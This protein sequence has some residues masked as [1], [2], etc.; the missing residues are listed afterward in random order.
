MKNSDPGFNMTN[1]I[2]GAYFYD[3]NPEDSKKILMKSKLL[4]HPNI[5]KV[6]FCNDDPPNI[7]PSL[8]SLTLN[9]IKIQTYDIY[10]HPGYFDLF[11]IP[12]VAGRDFQ[13]NIKA[14]KA[15]YGE[16]QLRIILNETAA[17]KFNLASPVGATGIVYPWNSAVEI[18]G[19]VKDFHIQSLKTSIPPIAFIFL[20]KAFRTVMKIN[21]GDLNDIKEYYNDVSMQVFGRSDGGFRVVEDNYKKQYRS[22]EQLTKL[23]LWFSLLAILI[24]SMG[25]Y[26]ISINAIQSRVKEIGIRK[27]HGASSWIIMKLLQSYFAKIVIWAGLIA[28]P[29]S[30]FLLSRWLLNYPYKTELSWWIFLGALL[31]ALFIAITTISWRT[32]R[33]ATSNPVESIKYE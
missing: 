20:P 32:W 25:L 17:K 15:D 3:Q 11:E 1:V 9:G 18:I 28:L 14:D 4:Q 10:T 27:V 30:W 19:V 8:G 13:D 26:G 23:F 12:I 16:N 21:G 33:A 5:D 22:E 2:S 29:V 6:V 31:F 7:E 24:A